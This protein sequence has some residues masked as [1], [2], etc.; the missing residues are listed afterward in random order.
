MVW[1]SV[2]GWGLGG[3][4]WG[5]GGAVPQDMVSL[6]QRKM[7]RQLGGQQ[8]MRASTNLEAIHAAKVSM[9]LKIGTFFSG[10]E[11]FFVVVTRLLQTLKLM[12]EVPV[13]LEL[14]FIAEQHEWK[15]KFIRTAENYRVQQ[16]FSDVLALH[17]AGWRGYNEVSDQDEAI[18]YCD[19][20]GSGFECDSVSSLGGA[21]AVGFRAG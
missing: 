14:A 3:W 6:A 9:P 11:V 20:F 16:S 2:G 12:F 13:T 21:A 15:R 8:K 7:L 5:K 4:V 18:G 19:I 17:A 10:S 1:G